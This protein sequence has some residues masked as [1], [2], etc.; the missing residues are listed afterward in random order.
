MSFLPF[1]G[2]FVNFG[3]K[4]GFYIDEG[5]RSEREETMQKLP[6]GRTKQIY[7]VV[8]LLDNMDD[9]QK[10]VIELKGTTGL[11]MDQQR[12]LEGNRGRHTAGNGTY[13]CWS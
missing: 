6:F 4:G 10:T 1:F 11:E 3:P 8:L 9:L 13:K 12:G 7:D 5:L 2:K